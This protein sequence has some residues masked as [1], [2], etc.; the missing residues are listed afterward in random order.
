[1]LKREVECKVQLS[2]P[3]SLF[4]VGVVVVFLSAA[5][6]IALTICIGI[7]EFVSR[8]DV[9]ERVYRAERRGYERGREADNVSSR[10]VTSVDYYIR[11]DGTWARRPTLEVRGR[12]D[13]P[14]NW[15]LVI[16][17][18]NPRDRDVQRAFLA[19]GWNVGFNGST[20]E[21]KSGPGCSP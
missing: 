20:I 15:D 7:G 11:T 14:C 8:D 19:G 9:H 16:V 10:T 5:M 6:G 4:C 18:P 2:K 21:W 12:A 17:L 13:R 1:M 3:S